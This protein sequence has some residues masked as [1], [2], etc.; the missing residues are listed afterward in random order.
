MAQARATLDPPAPDRACQRFNFIEL[1]LQEVAP[2]PGR[3]DVVWIQWCIGH[4]PDDDLVAF[5]RVCASSLAPG[6]VV[7]VKENNAKKGFVLDKE[8]QSVTRSDAYLVQLFRQSG[9]KL[10]A[11]QR[12]EEGL[13]EGLFAVR[14]YALAPP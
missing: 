14:A 2:Q 9:M 12:Q 8:D 3:Y 1:P 6:G 11:S 5:L 4:L 10:L 7:V 13:P